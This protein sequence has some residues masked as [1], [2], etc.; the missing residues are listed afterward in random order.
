MLKSKRLALFYCVGLL[1]A[2]AVG[3]TGCMKT[4]VSSNSNNTAVTYVSVLNVAAYSP[5][6]D[7]YFNGTKLTNAPIPA[8]SFSTSYSALPPNAYDVQFK[9]GGTDSV[10][11]D[12]P[13]SP[14]DS[15]AFNTLVLYNDAS[16]GPA[17]ATKIR[18]DFSNVSLSAANYR[19]FNFSPDVPSVDLYLNGTIVQSSRRVADNVANTA[20]NTFQPVNSSTY[21]IVVKAAGKDSVI[22]YLNGVDLAVQNVYTIFLTGKASGTPNSMTV[23]VLRAAY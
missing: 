8:G 11:A 12:I 2:G 1:I 21:N 23:N 9:A 5:A 14:Y 4:G 7:I 6:T 15:A 17:R 19:F 18:D 20:Y 22:A 16:R 10:M 13:S 3:M